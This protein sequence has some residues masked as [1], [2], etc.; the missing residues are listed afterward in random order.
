MA[1]RFKAFEH[2]LHDFGLALGTG[3]GVVGR[4][5][6]AVGFAS[7]RQGLAAVEVAV[8]I[9]QGAASILLARQLLG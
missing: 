5:R 3:I 7:Q 2:L 1:A 9:A 8:L 6:A 4:L